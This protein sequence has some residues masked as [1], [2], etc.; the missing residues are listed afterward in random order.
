MEKNVT[1][2]E[3]EAAKDA[4]VSAYMQEKQSIAEEFNGRLAEVEAGYRKAQDEYRENGKRHH[5][6]AVEARE[7]YD[8]DL[9]KLKVWLLEE[10]RKAHLDG[11]N[12]D[13]LRLLY[14]KSKLSLRKELNRRLDANDKLTVMD[15]YVYIKAEQNW[16]IGVRGL[17][18]RREA[19]E[20]DAYRFM[21]RK[22]SELPKPEVTEEGGAAWQN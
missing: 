3:Y 4:V 16:K 18:A 20:I 15:K 10:E 17:S 13:E 8:R 14:R 19:C 12:I 6:E 1:M 2:E 5:R 22:M 11:R 21:L 9:T 7:R